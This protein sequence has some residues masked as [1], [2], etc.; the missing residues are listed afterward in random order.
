MRVMRMPIEVQITD[1]IIKVEQALDAQMKNALE[2]V[3]ATAASYASNNIDKA[4]RVA[5]S[6]LKQ[7]I[8]HEVHDNE[9]Y[10]GTNNEYAAYHELGTGKYST[11]GG[12]PGFWVYVNGSS[13]KGLNTGKRYTE[14]EARQIVAILKSKGLDAHMTEGIKPIHFIRDALQNNMSKFK[15]IIERELS[16]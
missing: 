8:T 1:N 3:G 7:S 11:Q 13:Q 15:A 9:V 2:L 10:V 16:D 14:K 12:R 6:A 4:G 5:T